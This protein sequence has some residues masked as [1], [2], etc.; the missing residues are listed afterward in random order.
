MKEFEQE[1]DKTLKELSDDLLIALEK[2]S[3]SVAVGYKRKAQEAI[4][5]A[6]EAL[7]QEREE[8]LVRQI[9]EILDTH[10]IRLVDDPIAQVKYDLAA[11]TTP[12]QG[13]E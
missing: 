2:N 11:L 3:I 1:L 9:N 6:I 10:Y 4:L 5:A 7:M 13:E 8:R 12:K